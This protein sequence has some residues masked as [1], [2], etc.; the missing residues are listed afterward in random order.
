MS[1]VIAIANE[2]GGVAKTTT[3]LSLGGAL[4]ENGQ[5]VLLV[6]LDPQGN[7]SLACGVKPAQVRRSMADVLLNSSSTLSV[8]RETSLPG[9]DLIPANAGMG[10]A[11]QFLPL[12]ENYTSLLREALAEKLYFDYILMDCPPSLGAITT[13]ALAAADLLIIPTQAEYF[14]SHALRNMMGLV[15][16]VRTE[17][18]PVLTFRVL[19]TM[20]DLRNRIHR[21]IREQLANSLGDGLFD[22]VIQIDTKLRESAVVGLPVTHFAKTTRSA[23]QYRAL[24]LE[25]TQNV[26]QTVAQPA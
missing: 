2:K 12:R 3:T 17:A 6:D 1:Y 24:A 16:Q 18:N 9:L 5:D 23:E 19:L 7:L 15:K 14:S 21:I 20:L 13:S 10:R 25:I 8:S 4:I 22:T 11:E 26:R